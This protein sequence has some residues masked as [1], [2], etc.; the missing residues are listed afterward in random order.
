MIDGTTNIRILTIMYLAV[1]RSF[2]YHL[3]IFND[4][5]INYDN[6]ALVNITGSSVGV[7]QYRNYINYTNLATSIGSAH[8]KF[9]LNLAKCDL[10]LYLCAIYNAG[11]RDSPAQ[12]KFDITMQITAIDQFYIDII[13]QPTYQVTL[14]R[15]SIV[16]MDKEDVER[17]GEFTIVSYYT[18][19]NGTLD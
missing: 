19:L 18:V 1:D 13:V 3:N 4:I 8:T 11:D 15:F 5:P 14:L 7:R 17:S 2:P 12:V 16:S 6:G 10:V 9:G